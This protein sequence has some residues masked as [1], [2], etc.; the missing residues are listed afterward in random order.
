MPGRQVEGKYLRLNECGWRRK[1]GMRDDE[2]AESV[3]NGVHA[4]H[5]C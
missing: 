1:L 2:S 3:A 4:G 5:T